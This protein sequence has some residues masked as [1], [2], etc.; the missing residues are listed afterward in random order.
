[1]IIR[2]AL[3]HLE[4]ELKDKFFTYMSL[5]SPHLGYMYN[6]SKLFDAGMWFLKKW[7]KSKCL[8]QLSMTD[9]KDTE[10]CALYKLSQAS[11][12]QHFK[13]VILVSSAQ[14]QY[15]PF[16]SARIQ[17][18][19]KASNDT[20]GKGNYYSTMVQNIVGNLDAIRILYRLDVNFKISDK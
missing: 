6:S 8:V 16:D 11:G 18:C 9:T 5:S 20:T 7:R 4:A 1:L 14:D 3:P 19:K 15:A 13:N 2:A 12:L 10:Q 17:M